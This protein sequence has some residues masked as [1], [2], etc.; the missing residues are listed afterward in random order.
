MVLELKK[1][2]LCDGEKQNINCSVNL[3]DFDL[4]GEYPFVSPVSVSGCVQNRSGIVQL[5]MNVVFEF[6]S[7]CD[8]CQKEIRKEYHEAFSHYLSEALSDNHSEEY[9][10]APDF[11]LD[12]DELVKSDILL[13]LPHKFLCKDDCKGLCMNCGKDLNEGSCDCNR[14][15]IDPRLEKLQQL[16]DLE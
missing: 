3:N 10:E 7:N 9:I 5:T 1:V 13:N 2:F 16:I 15:N 11:Q 6:K 14:Q 12:L 8:R 4:N